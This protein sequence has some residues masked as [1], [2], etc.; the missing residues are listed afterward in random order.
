L[1]S[2]ALPSDCHRLFRRW[3]AL[4][5]GLDVKIPEFVIAMQQTLAPARGDAIRGAFRI[6]PCEKMRIRPHPT[7]ALMRDQILE[8]IGHR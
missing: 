2:E 4:H 5:G 6:R 1:R 7:A 3:P 8:R